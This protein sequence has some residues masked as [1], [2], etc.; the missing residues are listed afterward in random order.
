MEGTNL[1]F[2]KVVKFCGEMNTHKLVVL[3]GNNNNKKMKILK[4]KQTEGELKNP[5]PAG[6]G[7][8]T[9]S[10]QQSAR[11]RHC[12]CTDLICIQSSDALPLI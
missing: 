5:V 9:D 1:F 3:P 10:P 8:S 6:G 2:R 11:W 4:L 7:Y 12:M